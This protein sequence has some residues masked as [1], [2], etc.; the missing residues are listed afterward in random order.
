MWCGGAFG[1]WVNVVSWDAVVRD[2]F[3]DVIWASTCDW[4]GSW[5][6]FDWECLLTTDAL[7]YEARFS[8][9]A[10]TFLGVKGIKTVL[11]D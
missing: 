11:F 10:R 7:A 4:K 5:T 9:E 6:I 3:Q 1:G 8:L 2:L